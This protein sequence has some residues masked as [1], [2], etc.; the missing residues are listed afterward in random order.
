MKFML[1]DTALIK[2]HKQYGDIKI[3]K[4][5]LYDML[6]AMGITPYV[7]AE[8]EYIAN[9]HFYEL[10]AYIEDYPKGAPLDEVFNIGL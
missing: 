1:L 4:I 2:L 3:D 6:F 10:C 9:I 8:R 5:K 7:C